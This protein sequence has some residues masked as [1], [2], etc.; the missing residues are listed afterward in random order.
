MKQLDRNKKIFFLLS[1]YIILLT[2]PKIKNND[3]TITFNE[4]Y[5]IEDNVPFAT[6]NNR[7]IYIGNQEFIERIKDSN[8]PDIYIIDDRNN[9][10]PDMAICNSFKIKT[11]REMTSILRVI[12]EY[13]KEYPSKWDRTLE[14]MEKEWLIHNLCY[15]LNIRTERTEEVDL[16]NKDEDKY[17][18]YKNILLDIYNKIYQ[19]NSN[20]NYNTLSSKYIKAKRIN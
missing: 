20:Q 18:S 1:T 7:E 12:L 4:N 3:N 10:D 11:Y 14:S 17:S 9:K 2:T 13:E 5:V 8:S 6:Y 15:F 19:N 16:N